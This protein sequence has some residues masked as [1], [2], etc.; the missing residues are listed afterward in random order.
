MQRINFTIKGIQERQTELIWDKTAHR[1]ECI[2]N[3]S[4]Q[5]LEVGAYLIL[6]FLKTKVKRKNIHGFKNCSII[7]IKMNQFRKSSFSMET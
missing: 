3:C 4:V 2:P 6:S 7:E 1:N 5:L